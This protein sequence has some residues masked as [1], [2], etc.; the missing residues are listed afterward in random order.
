MS[1]VL[2]ILYL[3]DNPNDAAIV[4][5][6]LAANGVVC[7]VVRVETRNAFEAELQTGGYD[8]IFSDYR[9]PAYDGSWALA[10]ARRHCPAVPFVLVSGT[11]GEDAAI[12]SLLEGATDYVLKDHLSRLIPSLE[13]ALREGENWRAR[14][15]AE[16]ALQASEQRYRRLFEAS[17]DG[18]L[19][20]DADSGCILDANPAVQE[21]L[22]Y[23]L[24]L[25]LGRTPLEVGICGSETAT[26][27]VFGELA[28][29]E[30]VHHTGV[31][32]S[33]AAGRSVEVE[34]VASAY[35]LDS[36]RIVQLNLR[37]SSERQCLEEQL[38]QSQ[39][40]EAVGR[41]AGGVAHDFNNMLMVINGYTEAVLRQ[42]PPEAPQHADLQ[43]VSKAVARA[44]KLTSQ[45]LA[46]SR[47]Q[48][49][50]L[51]VCSLNTVVRDLEQMLRRMAGE[52]IELK[53]HLSQVLG[54]VLADPGQIEQLLLNLVANSRDAMEQG[55]TIVVETANQILLPEDVKHRAD[56]RPGSY[57]RLSVSDNGCG[58]DE[59]TASRMFEPFFTTKALGKGTGLG[60]STVYG[61]VKQS[62]GHIEAETTV[63]KGTA[64]HIFLPLQQYAQAVAA[65]AQSDVVVPQGVGH[66]VLL[67]DD[68]PGVR[69]LVERAL[70]GAGYDV[71]AAASGDEAIQLLRDNDGMRID[72]LLTDLILPGMDGCE[73]ARRVLGVRPATKVVYMSGYAAEAIPALGFDA[74]TNLIE[75]P[76]AIADLLRRIGS[77]L[78]ERV[79]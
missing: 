40:L 57:V 46:F 72:L 63:G 76:F 9:L 3:E 61:I 19:L 73:L 32:L 70:K 8:V 17:T 36:Q 29:H 20:L 50:R 11:V 45:L 41:L 68:D 39:T 33:A 71:L 67:V 77:L 13:R 38:R 26:R 1:R 56:M 43:E 28:T 2:R 59:A 47:K 7:E 18:I 79:A 54:S 31:R 21:L 5:D 74:Q 51:S 75:K 24:P 78:R 69:R 62:G 10:F 52:G 37:D 58:M 49:M 27:A 60:L 64:I 53:L 48:V 22:G 14:R 25:L 23:A 42:L 4:A 16:R 12:A 30:Q 15:Q 35:V 66:G 34:F 55:G 44:A 65:Q 6:Y